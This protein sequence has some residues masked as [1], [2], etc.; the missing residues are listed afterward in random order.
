MHWLSDVL[1]DPIATIYTLIFFYIMCI[2]LPL[3]ERGA[4]VKNCAN[5]VCDADSFIDASL[6]THRIR[7]QWLAI[8]RARTKR[9][10]RSTDEAWRHSV[11]GRMADISLGER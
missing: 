8:R 9:R 6:T 3:C 4:R 11:S 10:E 5:I 1:N 2:I 7:G